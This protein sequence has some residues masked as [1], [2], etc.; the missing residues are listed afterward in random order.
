M[1]DCN[2]D[3][4]LFSSLYRKT[5]A[6]DFQGGRLTSDGGALLLAEVAQQTGLFDALNAVIPDPRDPRFIIHDQRAMLAQRVIAIA[7]G[8]EDLNDHQTLRTDPVLQVGA[9]L[10]PDPEMPLASPPTLCRL[11]NRVDRQTLIKMAEVLVDQFVTAHPQAPEHL[12]LDFD[13]TDDPVHGRQEK[14]FFHG[15]YDH[16]CFLPLYAFAG[17]ELVTAY[18]RPSNI[19][20]SRHARAVLKLLVRKL[21]ATWPE[22]KITLRADSGFCRWRLMRWCDSHGI[23]YILG[24][25]KNPALERA[26]RDEIE[27]AERQFHQTS[28]PQRIFG[29]FGYAATTWDR[30]RRVIVKAEHTAQGKNPRF[31]VSNVP[32]DP[33][34]LYEDVYCQRGEAENRIKEQQ[35]DLFADRTSCHQF[36]ANQFRVLLSSAAYVL[37]QALR[38]TALVGTELAQAQVST[39]RLKLFKVAARVV[40]TAR[41]VVFHLSSSYPYQTIFR[42]VYATVMG[43]QPTVATE[44]G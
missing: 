7:L 17:D 27:R 10:L 9:G 33:Q 25:A 22:V 34:E 39:I 41:R 32:G 35:L 12:I 44:S 42:T 26:A 20:A 6:A 21:R 2:R 5:V 37:V 16:H 18:L 38:R 15:Y 28:E 13:A 1:T 4:L 29:S 40:V 14:R 8:Y 19:D 31:V 3:P 43:R 24:L 23:G 11:E 30:S 36:L